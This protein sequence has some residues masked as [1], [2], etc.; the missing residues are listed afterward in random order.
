MTVSSRRAMLLMASCGFLWSIGGLF[1]KLIPWNP[2]VIAG[3][4]SFIAALVFLVYLKGI[5]KPF[6]FNSRVFWCG[7]CLAGTMLLFV[8]ANKLTTSANAIILQSTSPVFIMVISAVFLGS[9]Y[10]KSEYAVVFITLL[11]IS[12]FFFDQL[13]PGNL[14]GNILAL[15][16]GLFV[17]LLFVLTSRLPDEE[18]SMSALLTGHLL[19][20][21]VGLPFA[22]V[23]PTSVTGSAVGALLVLGI[24]QLGIPYILYGLASRNCPPLYCSLI[25]MIEP[26]FNPV[27]VFLVVGELPGFFAIIGGTIVLIT[28]ATWCALSARAVAAA[29]DIK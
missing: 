23:F 3:G 26:L 18:S 16:S 25:G 8:C 15:G 24:F 21:L 29:P 2:L 13:S 20:A 9:R 14:A 5:K 1:I 17:A 19:T 7:A 22:F 6:C 28:V 27:W 12:L 4:R 11:G 10:R